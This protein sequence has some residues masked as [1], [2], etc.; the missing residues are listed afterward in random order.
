MTS[1]YRSHVPVLTPGLS[2]RR[3]FFVRSAPLLI[4]EAT[5]SALRKFAPLLRAAYFEVSP[6]PR[7]DMPTI[8][9]ADADAE[10]SAEFAALVLSF[11]EHA[12]PA[13]A[14]SAAPELG[15][16]LPPEWA[17]AELEAHY[18]REAHGSGIFPDPDPHPHPHPHPHAHPH[19]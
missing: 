18:W 3:P 4:H 19:P 16:S 6:T 5:Y 17:E 13:S 10:L 7:V 14:A 8:A 12:P 2:V 11:R 15:W 1:S 9:S